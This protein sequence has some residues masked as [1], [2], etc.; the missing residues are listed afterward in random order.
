VPKPAVH[1]SE[2]IRCC[3]RHKGY[4]IPLMH[5]VDHDA[6]YRTAE[7]QAG[8]FTTQQALAAGMDRSTMRHHARPGGRYERVRRARPAS[9]SMR[10]TQFRQRLAADPQIPRYRERCSEARSTGSRSGKRSPLAKA[11]SASRT[12][13]SSWAIRRA[14]GPS[15]QSSRFLSG[16]AS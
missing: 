2:H 9:I 7:S 4:I 10:L 6:L 8:Y 1:A 14:P 12:S 16:P 13:R 3:V 15:T 5:D 11:S